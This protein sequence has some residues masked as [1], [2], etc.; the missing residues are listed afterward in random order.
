M[1]GYW[2]Q[3]HW[4]E[5]VIGVYLPCLDLLLLGTYEG[6]GKV[7]SESTVAWPNYSAGRLQWTWR[8]GMSARY[9]RSADAGDA[10]K[11]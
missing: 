6:V 1:W 9:A 2:D 5:Y 3:M 11:M 10:G 4:R 8:L 7:V